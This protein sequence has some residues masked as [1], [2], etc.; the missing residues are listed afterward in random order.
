M[1]VVR[2]TRLSSTYQKEKCLGECRDCAPLANAFLPDIFPLSLDE[3]RRIPLMRLQ[4]ASALYRQT[5][6]EERWLLCNLAGSGHVA[7]GDT[8][9]MAF[10]DHFRT[11][12]QL[13]D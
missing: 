8:E 9:A 1:T 11:P 13:A 7:V 4:H 6:T 10:F 3:Q 12:H 5:I 2:N